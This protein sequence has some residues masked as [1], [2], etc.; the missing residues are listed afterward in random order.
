MTQYNTVPNSI[1][2]LPPRRREKERIK[3]KIRTGNQPGNVSRQKGRN[4][5]R[6]E[7]G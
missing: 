3:A 4:G 5:T 6:R 1:V 7:L 2:L